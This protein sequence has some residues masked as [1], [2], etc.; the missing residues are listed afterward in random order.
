MLGNKGFKL[1]CGEYI[2]EEELQKALEEYVFSNEKKNEKPKSS[3]EFFK[4]LE[5]EEITLKPSDVKVVDIDE[6]KENPLD[7]ALWRKIFIAKITEM[8]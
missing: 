3:E 6:K 4:H 7:F 2:L 5:G 1:P 8:F